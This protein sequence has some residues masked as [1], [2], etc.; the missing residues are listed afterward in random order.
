MA[1]ITG[2]QSNNSLTGNEQENDIITGLQGDDTLI[3]LSGND[4]LDGGEGNDTLDGGLGDDDLNGGNGDDIY[5]INRDLSGVNTINDVAGNDTLEIFDTEGTAFAVSLVAPTEGF[6]GIERD[7]ANVLVDIGAD[8]IAD[9]LIVEDFFASANSNTPGAGFIE[10]FGVTAA[11]DVQDFL[12]VNQPPVAGIGNFEIR[13]FAANGTQVGQLDISDPDGD[14]LTVSLSDASQ[15]RLINT[16]TGG[17]TE[18]PDV[19]GDGNAPFA[20]DNEGVITVNDTDDLGPLFDVIPFGNFFAFTRTVPSFDLTVEVSDGEATTIGAANIDVNFGRPAFGFGDPHVTTFDR[21]NFGFQVVGEFTLVES[22]DENNPLTIQA[23]TAP[24]IQENGEP[25]DRLSN[26][27]AIG[28][29]ID[30]NTVAIYAGED[31]PVFINGEAQVDIPVDGLEVGDDGGRIVN[32]GDGFFDISLGGEAQERIVVQVFENRIDPRFFL[33]EERNGNIT[34][35]MG[36]KDGDPSNDIVDSNGEV[37]AEATFDEINGEFADAFRITDGANSLLLRD[38]ED[39]ST[40]NDLDFPAEEVSLASLEEDL[41]TEAFNE[42]LAQ[43]EEAGAPEGFLKISAIIDLA[44]TGDESFVGSALNVAGG[45]AT[46]EVDNAV[47]NIEE[48]LADGEVVGTVSIR[49]GDDG[50]D[51]LEVIFSAGNE[52]VDGDGE[53]PFAIDGQGQITI[54]DSGDLV[55]AGE[56]E[57]FP[58]SVTATD[59]LGATGTGSVTVVENNPDVDQPPNVAANINDIRENSPEGTIVGRANAVDAEGDDFTF[60]LEGELDPDGDGTDAFTIAENGLITVADPGD[61]DFETTPSF[62]F[63]ITATQTNDDTITGTATVT[64]NLIDNVAPE[65]DQDPFTFDTVDLDGQGDDDAQNGEEVGTV[66]ATDA[67]G[68][69]L[70][71][72]ITSGNDPDDDGTNAFAIDENGQI[73]IV[74]TAELLGD[75]FEG[76]LTVTVTD[77]EGADEATVVIP[78]NGPEND[79]PAAADDS[80]STAEDTVLTVEAAGVLANDTDPE[81]EALEVSAVNGGEDNVGTE[82]TLDSGALLTLNAD[83]SY[84]YDPNGA[85]DE[86]NDGETDTDTFTYTVSDGNS[87]DTADVEIT[88]EGITPPSGTPV[89]VTANF[90][91]DNNGEPG[92]AIEDGT[93]TQGD[94]FFVEILVAADTPVGV[95]SFSLNIDFDQAVLDAISDFEDP[96]SIIIE[97]FDFDL[98]RTADLNE[99]TITLA[100]GTVDANTDDDGD[101]VPDNVIGANGNPERFALLEFNALE[102]TEDS[103]LDLEFPGIDADGNPLGGTLGDGTA[104]DSDEVNLSLQDASFVVDGGEENVAPEFDQDSFTFDTVDLDGAGDDDA[105]NGDV[106]GTVTATDANEGDTLTFAITGGN[107][108]DGDDVDAFAIDEAS[109][110]V[111]IV[112]TA[113]LLGDGFNGELTVTVTDQDDAS[114][115][116][117]VVIPVD[118][119]ENDPP[120]AADDS[121]ST[122]EDTVLTVEAAGV[123]ANDT[124]PDGDNLAV[125]AVN[126]DEANVGT[127]IT[128]ESGA[129]LTLNEDGSYEYDPNGAFDEL[130]DGETDVDTFTYTVSD[131]NSTDTA[132]VEITVEGITPPSGTPVEVTAN[133]LADNNGEPGD[134]IEDGTITQGDN[135]FVEILVAADTPVGVSSF[136][137]NIDFEQAVLDAL[138]DFETPASIITNQ[139]NFEESLV[140]EL[141][142]GT[143]TLAGGTADATTDDDGDGVPDNVI[144]ANGNPERFALLEFNALEVTEDSTL[145]LEFPGIDADGNPLGGTLGDGTA[146]D[147][148]EVNLSLQDASFVVDGGE[149]NVAPEFDQDSFTFDTVDLDGAGDD[150]AEN[151]DV[152]GTVTAT[153]ANEGDTL[154]FAI[155]GGNDPDEDDVDA[156]AI[157]EASGEVTIVDTAE[158]LGDGFN[159]E[160]TVTVTDQDDASDEATVVIPV[161]GP[162]ENDPPAAADDSNSTAEDTVL[163]VEAAGVLANDTDPE[164]EALEVSAV[165]GGED[166]V[167]TEITLDSGALLTLNA[168]GSYEYDPNGA[169]DELNDGETDVDTFTYTVSDGNS[170]DTAA[171]EIT[172]EGI[173][174]QP[175]VVGVGNFEI[176]E[177]DANGTQVGQLDISDPDGDELTVSLSEASQVRLINTFTGGTTEDP[178][179]DGDDNAPFAIDNE[180]VITV[181][182]TDDLGPLFNVIPFGNFFAFTRTV[183]SFDLTVEVSDGEATT[184]GAANIDVNFGRP[185]FGFGDPHVT[186]FDRN[187][188]GFQVVGEFTLVES[189]TDENNPLNIQARTAP[190]TQ[191]DGE[192]SDSLSNYTAI[193]TEIDGNTVAI[194]AGE[195]NPVFINGEA[196]VDIPV[197]GL[198]V[199]DDGGRIVNLGN[200][201]FNISLG[202]EAQER[203]VVQVFENRIDPRF[204]LSEERNGNITGVMGNKDGDP[205]NDIVNSNGEVI[206][207]AT[208]DEINGEFADAFRITD[209]ANSLL[210]RDGEDIGAINDTDF[211][212]EEVTLTSLEDDLGTDTFNDIVEQAEEAGVPEEGFLRT[213]AIIDFATTGDE[214]FIGSA[215]NVAGGNATPEVDNTVF[216]IEEDLGD[217][218]V[219]GTV[220]IR[221]GDDGLDN[222]TV[223]FSA[224]NEDIDGDGELPFAIDGQGQITVND[225]DDLVEAGEGEAFP[226]SVTATD[227]L[228]ATGTGSVTVVEN[229]PDVDQPPSVA[230]NV[231]DIRENSAEGTIVGQAIAVDAE[232]DDFTFGLEGEL[233]P[234]NN[235]TDA[236]TIDPENGLITVADP[237][238]LDFETTPSFEF[239]ITATQ[240]NDDTITGTS[241]VTV[242]LIDV[243]PEPV[244]PID[245]NLDVDGS[246]AANGSVDGLNILRVLFNLG[247]ETMDVSQAP[248]EVGQQNI[249]DNIQEGIDNEALDVDGSG[250]ANGS[251]DGLN[252]LRV[253]FNLGPETMDVSQAPEGVGQQNI[254]DNVENLIPEA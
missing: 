218:E 108:P 54:N 89:E 222:L 181:N 22:T 173:T 184:I 156:F 166:N 142:G 134:A 180:G 149:E 185:A 53:L 132:D 139:F 50:L 187:N 135:F 39:I 10:T 148:D 109:G 226:L 237:G 213:S 44:T 26:Y 207:E 146:I 231:N 21:N 194:Y 154:T 1:D 75:S 73:T 37:I 43:V 227:P 125:S 116:A 234:N 34:G 111:T 36:N 188:F 202:G 96:E 153:D 19:D 15:V 150:D 83:G 48:D 35:V 87:T 33:S 145:D 225:S 133:F 105:E 5:Q 101:G 239:D 6:I 178:D 63:D 16:F 155:T 76:E 114:D 23:R 219:V 168:D 246:G 163:T 183:P 137:L 209:G 8:G 27:T 193:A 31:N 233:N 152:V 38:G 235:D 196:Q 13:E 14:E 172:I 3:G 28:T 128:L 162:P 217:G 206:P 240:T 201:F 82:I 192:T 221:D 115:E 59:P 241:T 199:G 251:V 18:D 138:S 69:T 212:A 93:I 229:N 253:L 136:S 191:D 70:T 189:T 131:G 56:G 169:F 66:T 67:N 4:T 32:L 81:G 17:T 86:L 2:D 77:Q 224:G 40:I 92:D 117:T 170:T 42:I 161:D 30:G 120:A 210:L 167:G 74:D 65:F 7:G 103:T 214:S 129:L 51:N 88:V 58:L 159:G 100:G 112:D 126:G 232:G 62:E 175:P 47:F 211:P 130:N 122:A 200:G 85:F 144:G 158:L 245:F 141:D 41:G 113:E 68:D 242:N 228:G 254:F 216:N 147:S 45:N 223:I 250:A 197:D 110:E 165:N 157:D 57:A 71:F 171:V 238:D 55:E 160:L 107:D 60:G 102:V 124:D 249:F 176:D 94:N 127:E 24:A 9:D 195:D 46:P 97:K 164:G 52:D 12:A 247:P 230:A 208:F 99:G 174:N 79:P 248:E 72:A 252:I 177:F 64:V 61:L 78:V 203:I 90:L 215:L 205:S 84:E 186:T 179:V 25:S 244:G 123:L 49:D 143:I 104:I 20:I 106:V 236:F 11:R 91:A 151:G 121:N 220:S 190:A 29:E 119:P 118:G 182:D 98:G 243:E 204:F 95:S 198:E 140:A 80:N